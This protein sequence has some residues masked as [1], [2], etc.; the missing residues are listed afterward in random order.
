[1]SSMIA[2]RARAR[3]SRREP[4]Y[5][6][7]RGGPTGRRD[8]A[9]H[10]PDRHAAERRHDRQGAALEVAQLAGTHLAADLKADDE[11]NTD[12]RTSLTKK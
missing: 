11:K 2:R 10:R 4:A 12:I 1:M 9:G 6:A 7:T 5:P 8:D 3:P